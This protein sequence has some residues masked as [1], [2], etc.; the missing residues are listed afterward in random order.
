M[1]IAKRVREVPAFEVFVR[2]RFYSPAIFLIVVVRIVQI[3]MPTPV[4]AEST[5]SIDGALNADNTA[6]QCFSVELIMFEDT[7]ASEP[8]FCEDAEDDDLTYRIVSQ[9]SNGTASIVAGELLYDPNPD[10]FGT[11]SFTYLASDT[12]EN[13]QPAIASVTVHP[14][15]DSPVGEDDNYNA[16]FQSVLTV[17]AAEGLLANDSDI[18][19][20]PL[21]VELVSSTSHGTLVLNPDGSFTY[22]P[23]AG[24]FGS[25]SFTYRCDDGT[26]TSE[27]ITVH[28][29]VLLQVFLPILRR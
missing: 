19:N 12:F 10:Y 5:R 6:P 14:V 22:T 18:E 7:D 8:P 9:P 24:Y 11:D 27:V 29:N 4:Y 1:V 26:D 21:S 20:D 16:V 13:S 15:N 17:N 23:A 28:I 3:I 25:D 2:M